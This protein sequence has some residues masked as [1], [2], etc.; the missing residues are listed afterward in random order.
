ML[1]ISSIEGHKIRSE[2][3]DRKTQCQEMTVLPQIILNASRIFKIYGIVQLGKLIK[4]LCNEAPR[5]Y[6][7]V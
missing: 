1:K 4:K 7:T 3:M 6:K 5:I 2:Y